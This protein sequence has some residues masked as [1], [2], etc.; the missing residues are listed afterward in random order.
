MISKLSA[1]GIE[2][3]NGD[4]VICRKSINNKRPRAALILGIDFHY[5]YNLREDGFSGAGC[6]HVNI[7]II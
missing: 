1:P 7:L 2:V 3:E 4:V 6:W 5:R